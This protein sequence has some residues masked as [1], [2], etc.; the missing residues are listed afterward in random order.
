[1]AREITNHQQSY[2]RIVREV[3]GGTPTEISE[4]YVK[5][6]DQYFYGIVDREVA[7]RELGVE[8]IQLGRYLKQTG[9]TQLLSILT[10]EGIPREAFEN[11]FADGM[12]ARIYKWERSPSHVR[13]EPPSADVVEPT[14]VVEPVVEPPPAQPVHQPMPVHSNQSHGIF[15]R[16]R[17]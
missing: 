13:T 5:L 3:A 11:A 4:S 9:N 8:A 2:S 10:G 6:I 17:R 16:F 14:R 15:R 1:L 7:A 12:R